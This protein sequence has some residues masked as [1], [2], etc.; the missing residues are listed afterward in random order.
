M[1]RR[2]R[3]S[4]AI[5]Y[6]EKASQLMDTDFHSCSMLITCYD[7]AGNEPAALEAARRT[8]ARAEAAGEGP[9]ERRR[10]GCRRKLTDDDGRDRTGEGLGPAGACCSTPTIS[11]SS[12]MRPAA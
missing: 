2:N 7:G 11:G 3:M 12:I 6:F 5:R 9:D 1:F 8:L 4:D 10:A